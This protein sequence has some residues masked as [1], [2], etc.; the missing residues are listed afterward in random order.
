MY[1]DDLRI[2]G[3]Q[4]GATKQDIRKAYK[5]LCLKCH[6]DKKGSAE[7]FIQLN[8]AYNRLME[9]HDTRHPRE[10]DDAGGSGDDDAV[11][12]Y[13]KMFDIFQQYILE[14]LKNNVATSNDTTPSPRVGK[15]DPVVIKLPVT[16]ED[17]CA[18]AV[19]CVVVKVSRRYD[20]MMR[21]E[22]E[23]LYVSLFNYQKR[24]IVENKGDDCAPEDDV[25][26]SP[27]ERGDVHIELDVQPHEMVRIC[28]RNRFNLVC[29]RQL[30]LPEYIT[31]YH[32]TFTLFDQE[33]HLEYTGTSAPPTVPIPFTTQVVMKECGLPYLETVKAGDEIIR[34][35]D[36]VVHIK[37]VLLMK[38]GASSDPQGL[39]EQMGTFFV[40]P[41]LLKGV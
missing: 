33:R 40:A 4:R 24:Y 6:P 3:L 12:F 32:E 26:G 35:G 14:L 39:K 34:H 13:K 37:L 2:L 17:I 5:R 27:L 38:D 11:N 15:V 22:K 31:G 18:K 21:E 23:V 19:K 8:E 28:S 7:E 25:N 30:G 9:R 29:E 16:L 10:Q 36:L 20:I 41:P 1:I